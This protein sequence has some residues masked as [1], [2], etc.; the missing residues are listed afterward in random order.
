MLRERQHGI[1]LDIWTRLQDEKKA[2]RAL[3]LLSH[4]VMRLKSAVQHARQSLLWSGYG[5][6]RS[7]NGFVF[8][9]SFFISF[10]IYLFLGLRSV[11][12]RQCEA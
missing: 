4:R 6:L 9:V 10:F 7:W 2:R 5:H 8:K 3:G 12:A 11:S 1:C